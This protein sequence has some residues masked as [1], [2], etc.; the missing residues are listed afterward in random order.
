VDPVPSVKFGV[1][2]LDLCARELR[3]KGIRLR[4]PD[5]SLEVLALLVQ[6]PGQLVSR[7]EIRQRLWPDG[8]VVEF[9]HGVNNAVMRLRD[10]LS[11]SADTPRFVETLPRR[12]YRFVAPVEAIEPEAPVSR[13]MVADEAERGTI[14][15]VSPPEQPKEEAAPAAQ[16]P[17]VRHHRTV[18]IIRALGVAVVVLALLSVVLYLTRPDPV[19]ISKFRFTPFATDPELEVMGA[20]SPDGKSVAYLKEINGRVQVMVRGLDAAAPAQLTNLPEGVAATNIVSPVFWS[21]EGDRIY[22]MSAN[23]LWS[24]ALAGGQPQR[25]FAEEVRAAAISPDGKTLAIWRRVEEGGKVYTSLWISKPPGARPRKYTPAPFQVVGAFMPVFLRFSPDGTRIAL[26]GWRTGIGDSATWI[27]PWPD[28]PAATPRQL[29]PQHRMRVPQFDWMPDS[30]HLVSTGVTTPSA[31]L[32]F[33]DVER[34]RMQQLTTP[35][36]TGLIQYPSVSP[37]GRRVLSS[38]VHTDFDI[39]RVPLDGSPPR[40]ALS[41]SM[42][43]YSP[44]WSGDKMAFV[45]ERSGQS[46]IW[47]SSMTAG[48]ERPLVRQSDF[49]PGSPVPFSDVALSPDGSRVAYRRGARLWISPAAG[50]APSLA[51]PVGDPQYTAASWSPDGSSLVCQ[52]S[53]SGGKVVA[54]ARV[55]SREPPRILAETLMVCNTSPLWSPD[56]RWIACGHRDGM[57]LLVSPDGSHR[58]TI[59]SPEW[60]TSRGFVLVWSRDGSTLYEASSRSGQ[61]AWLDAIDVKTGKSHRVAEYDEFVRFDSPVNYSLSG[62]LA[63]DGKSFF[64]TAASSKSDLWILDG[65]PQPRRKWFWW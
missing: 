41:T 37:D 49:P 3:K 61:K 21:P 10:A 47:L 48:W 40:P 52:V 50:G 6:R 36:I 9:E 24:I 43:E 25:I 4:V 54:V 2:Q 7:E 16:L 17:P 58:R 56:G 20:W 60:P 39:V 23:A 13:Q 55:G 15:D 51:I 28:G 65:F 5:Q 32:Y 63:P 34:D 44:S 27:L 62:S 38:V 46:E 8:T 64:T 18:W 35:G 59:P 12:G 31:A 53:P 14:A 30:R 42:D 29:S 57:L 26:S 45:T 22:F 19:E 33:W 1:F 11:D